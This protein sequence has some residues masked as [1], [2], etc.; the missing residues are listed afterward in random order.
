MLSA[1]DLAPDDMSTASGMLLG[2]ATGTAGVLYIGIG[3]LKEVV[4]IAPAM[5]LSFLLLIPAAL[6]A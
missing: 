5:R 1:Q 4:G 3:R 2:L 6:L